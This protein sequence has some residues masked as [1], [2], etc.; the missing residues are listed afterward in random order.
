MPARVVLATNGYTGDLWPGLRRS[1]IAPNSFQVAT[2]PLSE[3]V[4]RTILPQGHVS[5]DTRQ[6]LFY[7]R[8]DHQRGS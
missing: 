4:A 8:L 1:I 3:A 6:L 2:E 5:S 7:F